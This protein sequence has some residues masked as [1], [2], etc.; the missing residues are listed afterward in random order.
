[1]MGTTIIVILTIFIA[2]ILFNGAKVVPQR[3]ELVI[4]RLGRY[5][6]T[7]GAGFHILIPFLDRVAYRRSLKEEVYDIGSQ[8]C[9]TKDNVQIIVDGVLYLQVIDSRLSCYG[10]DNY[11]VAA[12]NLA[13]TS[14]RSVVGKMTLDRTFEERE[15]LNQSVVAAVDEAAQNWGVKVLRYEVQD[16][17]V[18][19]EIMRAMEKQM[20]AERD[21]RATIAESEAERQSKINL[22]EGQKQ[23]SILTS[24]GEK[25][26]LINRAEGEAAE[27]KLRAD[28]TAEAIQKVAKSINAKGG[29]DAA[30]LEVAKEYVDQFGKLAKESNIFFSNFKLCCISPTFSINRFSNLLYC[31]CCSICSQFNFGSFTLSSINK[32]QFFTFRS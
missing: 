25:L 29:T 27:I 32:L 7:L 11:N 1:M 6:R 8:N 20:T 18:S 3:T 12:Q 13:Q 28:A 4:E 17:Q 31:F 24:E 9:I 16:L 30:Q 14:L 21:K 5:N 19:E 23:Q 15:F 10:I 22:A 2:V 26:Q